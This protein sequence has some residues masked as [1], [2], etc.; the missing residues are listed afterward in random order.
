MKNFNEALKRAM[1][2]GYT[3]KHCS[4][5]SMYGDPDES[6]CREYILLDKNFWIALGKAEGWDKEQ[7]SF[8]DDWYTKWAQLIDHLA[9]G[10]SIDE[11]FN[12][13]VKD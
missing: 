6:V 7:V 11:Y 2:A 8:L 4:Q 13:I 9:S 5:W 10:G 1:S 12:T 3:P